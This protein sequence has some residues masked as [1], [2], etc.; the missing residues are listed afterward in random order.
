MDFLSF[1]T[2]MLHAVLVKSKASRNMNTNI[3]DMNKS[4]GWFSALNFQ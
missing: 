2:I 3:Q 1:I 4:K